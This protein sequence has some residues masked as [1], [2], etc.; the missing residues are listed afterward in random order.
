M[1][2]VAVLTFCWSA[3]CAYICLYHVALHVLREGERHIAFAG[4]ALGLGIY[5]VGQANFLSAV[6]FEDA[7]WGLSIAGGGT[8]VGIAGLVIFCARL[9]HQWTRLCTFISLWG[10]LGIVGLFLGWYID[11]IPAPAVTP[12]GWEGFDYITPQIT[13]VGIVYLIVGWLCMLT[14]LIRLVPAA[15]SDRQTL[16]ILLGLS[17]SLLT[18]GHDIVVRVTRYQAPYLLEHFTLLYVIAMSYIVIQRGGHTTDQLS[19]HE[20]ALDATVTRLQVARDQRGQH[21]QLAMHGRMAG[22]IAHEIRNPLTSIKNA[23][24]SLGRPSPHGSQNTTLLNIVEAEVYRLNELMTD[25]ATFSREGLLHPTLIDLSELAEQAASRLSPPPK[26]G[27]LDIEVQG[28]LPTFIGDA[29]LLER[30]IMK[31]ITN[32]LLATAKSGGTVTLHIREGADVGWIELECQDTG[33][34]MDSATLNHALDPFFTTRAAG[35][36]LGLALVRKAAEMHGGGLT[37]ESAASLGT[38]VVMYLPADQTVSL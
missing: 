17:C 29:L 8:F 12:W 16:I 4:Y 38:K 11:P 7:L 30:A 14:A 21:A 18:G 9:E 3:I 13:T 19:A 23:A 37:L 35:V 15:R 2:P 36:G 22:A 10:V 34:G 6:C 32:G 27:A 5:S 20:T 24:A 33:E 1:P 25:L 28:K 26:T 31:L